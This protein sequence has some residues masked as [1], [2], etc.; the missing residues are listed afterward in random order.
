MV[1]RHSGRPRVKDDAYFG[2][3][4]PHEVMVVHVPK[5][6]TSIHD[7]S[8]GDGTA[9]RVF[10]AAGFNVTGSD[11]SDGCDFLKDDRRHQALISN[12]P[13][14]AAKLFIEHAL[15][16]ADFV[17]M[18]L[19]TN[20]A[21]AK[22]RRH[23]FADC[24]MFSKKIEL[25]RRIIFFPRPGASPSTNHAWFCWS[26]DHVGPPTLV[27]AHPDHPD[28]DSKVEAI[29]QQYDALYSEEL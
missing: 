8:C 13:Y 6:I 29:R 27:F 9:M 5:G 16:H 4:W 19:D 18:L 17:A 20:Y 10:R 2:E 22:T 7:P 25:L 3:A 23:L 21:H 14:R 28:D 15:A 26:R 24:P 1:Q 12:P 11:L